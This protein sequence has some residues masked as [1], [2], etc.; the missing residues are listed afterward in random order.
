VSVLVLTVDPLVPDAQTLARAASIIRDGGLVAFPTDTV[1]GIA[2][3]PAREDAV[4]RLYEAKGRAA[5]VAVPLIAGSLEQA[6]AAA[7][8]SEADER[9]ARAFWPGPLSIVAPASAHIAS[10]LRG[11]DGTVAVRVPDHPVARALALAFD[12]AIT[13]TSANLSGSP[14]AGSGR[15]AAAAL[16][17][18]VDAVLDAGP[19]PGGPPSTIVRLTDRGPQLLRRGAIAWERVLEFLP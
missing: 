16:D 13:A 3:D 7:R 1:Y 19:A 4:E 17:G 5:G 2:A 15:D 12:A 11:D 8:L 6:L 9:L 18:R 10:R 14:A